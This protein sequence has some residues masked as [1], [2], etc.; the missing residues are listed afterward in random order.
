MVDCLIIGAGPAGLTAGI[1]L[2]RFIR[3]IAIV[4]SGESRALSIPRTHNFPG[5]PDGISGP[6]LLRRLREQLADHEARVIR[7]RVSRLRRLDKTGFAAV[8]DVGEILA[9]T[10]LLATGVSDTEPGIDGFQAAKNNGLIRYCP[11]CDG[12][13]FRGKRIGVIGAGQHGFDEL[14]FL[15]NFSRRTSYI[16]ADGTNSLK[17]EWKAWLHENNVPIM[18]VPQTLIVGTAGNP[19][20][21]ARSP[22]GHDDE[23]DAIYCALGTRTRSDLATELGAACDEQGCLTVDSHLQTSIPGLFAAGD[24]VNTLNQLAVAVGQAAVASTAIHNRI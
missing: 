19:P 12:Y 16:P 3:N 6:T 2:K 17:S 20:L 13:E 8:T 23:F 5:F 24:V 18:E 7:A 11:I 21:L 9:K 14:K 4:D 22:S 10:V 1:Y 15:Q